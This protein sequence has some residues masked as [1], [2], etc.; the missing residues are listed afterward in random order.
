MTIHDQKCRTAPVPQEG[1]K[2][3]HKAR[4][5]Q[6]ARIDGIPEGS[7]RIDR[8][9]GIDR[10][11]LTT[12]LNNR[13]LSFGSPSPAQRRI[14]ANSCFIEK[15]DIR[16]T[17]FGTLPQLWVV[18][19]LPALDRLGIS[20]VGTPE[21]F[22][23]SNA[24]L[25]Q[26][27]SDRGQAQADFELLLDEVCHDFAR[28]ETKIKAILAR[29]FTVDP[30]PYLLLLLYRKL[31]AGSCCFT[32][33]QP[34]FTLLL[35]VTQPAV[36]GSSTETEALDHLAGVLTFAHSPDCQQANRLQ[37]FVIQCPAVHSHA[38]ILAKSCG[39]V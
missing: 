35:F 21:R 34:L 3:L 10:L 16:P 31:R 6:A 39:N 36:D 7:L 22:L 19:S 12:G 8:R 32:R 4:G 23:W 11:P 33:S 1:A 2:K 5:V 29:V 25:R 37:S 26:Q 27:A 15:E 20:L 13:C 24:Q 17:F 14:R 9:D 30:T 38:C 28:P 18:S